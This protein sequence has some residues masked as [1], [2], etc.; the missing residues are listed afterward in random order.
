MNKYSVELRDF[1]VELC[2][3]KIQDITRRN[4]EKIQITMEIN[5]NE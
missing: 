2:V 4:T 1:S 3:I 5:I